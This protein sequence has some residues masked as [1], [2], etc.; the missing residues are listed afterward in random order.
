MKYLMLI[1]KNLR[2]S[3][4]RSTLTALGTMVLVFVVTLV[5][6]I[7]SFLQLATEEKSQNL[8]AIVTERWSIPSRLPFSYAASLSQGAAEK[9]DDVRPLDSMTWQFFGGTLD[10]EN[11]TRENVIFG[12]AVEPAKILTMLDGLEDLSPVSEA[13]LKD[14]VEKLSNNRQGIIL[15]QNQLTAIN[16]RVGDRFTLSG[17]S[18]FRGIDLEFEILG[19]FPLGRYDNL[20]TFHRDYFN[21]E[22]DSYERRTGRKHPLADRRVNLVWLKVADTEAFNRVAS[23]IESSPLYTNPAVK[24]ET[25]S[26]GIASFLDAFRDLIWGMRWLLAPACILTLSMLIAN[27]IG[28]SVR[29]RR[30]EI[31]IMKVIGFR[32]YQILLLVL[33]ESL[34]LGGIAG[35]LSAILTYTI[36]NWGFGGLKFPIAFFDVFLIPIAS[37]W[38]GLGIGSLAALVGSLVPA[39]S[40]CRVKVVDV[41]S[42][43]A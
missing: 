18:G 15:G 8:K 17:I 26:S 5:W 6:S 9:P 7:L 28:I 1:L 11:F 40:A 21:N 19:T 41:F 33:T 31:A 3:L 34:V 35:L 42:K 39:W 38:W 12:I 36:V 20:A 24:C 27:A 29:E 10:P 25:A 23:Q 2:R 32:P 30:M 4:L 14:A 43:V 16:K 37:L 22:L 13:S